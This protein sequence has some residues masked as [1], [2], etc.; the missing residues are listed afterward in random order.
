MSPSFPVQTLART[1]PLP[2]GMASSGP[3]QGVLQMT[4]ASWIGS[5][6]LRPG[7]GAAGARAASTLSL[8]FSPSTRT[9]V[10]PGLGPPCALRKRRVSFFAGWRRKGI[11]CGPCS[12][13]RAP[14]ATGL[15]P[16]SM[17]ISYSLKHSFISQAVRP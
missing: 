14:V 1:L 9:S 13:L 2:I 15:T 7:G 16:S 8:T 10:A 11:R 6:A 17:K 12:A 3:S 5:K 4:L